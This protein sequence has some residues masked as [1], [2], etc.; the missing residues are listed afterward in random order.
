M[1]FTLIYL[2]SEIS[3][4]EITITTTLQTGTKRQET[5]ALEQIAARIVDL[6]GIR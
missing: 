4:D 6:I 3:I 1:L 5:I 2:M